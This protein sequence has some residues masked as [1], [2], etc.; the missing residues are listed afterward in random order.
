MMDS[1]D[2]FKALVKIYP[3]FLLMSDYYYGEDEEVL[4]C[5]EMYSFAKYIWGKSDETDFDFNPMRDL[6]DNFLSNGDEKV[7]YSVIACL[8][9]HLDTLDT[10]NCKPA[11]TLKWLRNLHPYLSENHNSWQDKYNWLF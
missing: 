4:F 3:D 10:Q 6:F 7:K 8:I 5:V 9:E 11:K 1:H 2:A